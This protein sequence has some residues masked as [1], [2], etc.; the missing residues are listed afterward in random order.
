MTRRDA[1]AV[2]CL[3]FVCST[4]PSITALAAADNAVHAPASPGPA[5]AAVGRTPKATP[6]PVVLDG[7]TLFYITETVLSITPAERVKAINERL[8]RLAKNRVVPPDTVHVSD[9]EMV[10]VI[11]VGDTPLLRL[12]D[13]DGSAAGMTRHALAAEYA[14]LLRTAFAEH[15]KAFSLHSLL[16][17]SLYAILGTALLAAMLLLYHSLFPRVYARI[18][19]WHE[20]RVRTLRIGSYELLHA[21]R[22]VRGLVALTRWFRIL[23]TTGFVYVWLLYVL[24]LFPWTHQVTSAIVGYI[25]DPLRRFGAAV[26]AFLPDLFVILVIIGITRFALKLARLF[27][28]EVGRGRVTIPGFYPEW[29]SPTYKIVRFVVIAFAV[30]VVF[31]YIP[32]SKSDAFKGVSIFLGLLVSLGS[33]SAIS[34]AIGGLT[35]T[36]MRAFRV[37]D[38]VR[39]GDTVGDVLEQGVLV[40]QLR[41]IKNENVTVPNSMVL[42]AHIVNFSA[43]AR[44][45]GLILHTS[46]TI[47]YDVPWRKVH[48]LLLEAARTTPDVLP[49]PGPFVLQT[50]LNDFYVTYELNAFTDRPREM[51]ETYSALHGRI[52]DAFNS[53]GVEIMSPHYSQLRDGN[54][55]TIPDAYLP[56]DYAPGGLRVVPVPPGRSNGAE[57]PPDAPGVRPAE[58]AKEPSGP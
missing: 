9:E 53:A 27:F 34:N 36:Y 17:S 7:K 32:G 2:I 43:R 22:I 39:I 52:Q 35:I 48:E 19:G 49:D 23:T 4:P 44:E 51:V 18:E 38:R 15:N 33:T 55:V 42:N 21:T 47:G 16:L 50:A 41:T 3:V 5:G 26:L 54:R 24:S 1:F 25:L 57:Q 6:A 28:T 20:T 14:E 40:T 45:E 30:T 56:P 8:G 31:P 37:G 10:S 11:Y 29:A 58:A 13:Q 12:L 46:V